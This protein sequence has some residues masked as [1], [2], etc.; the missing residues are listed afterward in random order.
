VA[1]QTA[2]PAVIVQIIPPPA[3]QTNIAD[4]LIGSLGI[5]A[6]AVVIAAILGL[7]LAW[8][9]IRWHRRHPPESDHLPSI[10]P[11]VA[12]SPRPPTGPI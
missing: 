11:L 12:G 9:L 10:S 8:L 3:P 7:V 4:V 6:I 2:P 5:T 1:W